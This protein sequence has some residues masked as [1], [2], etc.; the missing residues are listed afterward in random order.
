MSQIPNYLQNLDLDDIKKLTHRHTPE[1]NAQ[2]ADALRISLELLGLAHS[3]IQW[4]T[5]T[6][7]QK[8][9]AELYILRHLADLHGEIDS[10]ID[11]PSPSV[12]DI[13]NALEAEDRGDED[14]DDPDDADQWKED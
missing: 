6:T 4:A 3:L 7:S 5:R 14:N 9:R 10:S 1:D 12:A 8:D 2:S 11:S 13:L